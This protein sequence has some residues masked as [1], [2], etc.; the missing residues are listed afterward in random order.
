MFKYHLSKVGFIC[1]EQNY[2]KFHMKIVC[3]F[4]AENH[5]ELHLLSV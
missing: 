3:I 4:I 2:H 1:F 5:S